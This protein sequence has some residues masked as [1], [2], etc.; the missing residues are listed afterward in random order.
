M[1]PLK[2]YQDRKIAIYGMGLS[3]FSAAR[4]LKK[5]NAKILCWDDNDKIRKKIKNFNFTNSKNSLLTTI[6]WYSDNHKL[7]K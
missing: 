4:T 2:K 5:L 3:G 7:F 6:N 1:V